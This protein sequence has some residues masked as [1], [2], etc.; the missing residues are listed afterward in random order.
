MKP[1][2]FKGPLSGLLRAGDNIKNAV[3]DDD[4]AT[5]MQ[6]RLGA[7]IAADLTALLDDVRQ[8]LRDQTGKTSE[9]GGTTQQQTAAF[10]EV[11][12]LTSGAR[13]SARLA[14]PGEDVKLRSEFQVGI[15]SP[16]TLAA[17]LERANLIKAACTRYAT[18]LARQGWIARDTAAL[19]AA[20]DAC[21]GSGVDQTEAFADRAELTADLKRASNDLYD[22]LLTVQNAARL[23]YPSTRPGTEAARARFL[24]DT[25]PPRDRSQPDGGTEPPTPPTPPSA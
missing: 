25:F 16:K 2:K 11:E 20:I 22:K 15:D 17:E 21:S 24:L 4:Y 1:R 13:R 14:F 12:R 23:E 10:D 8:Q 18:D 3:Q 19:Q 7:T 9:A 6:E 5:K